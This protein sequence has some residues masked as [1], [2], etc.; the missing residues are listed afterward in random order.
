MQ[1][2][3]DFPHLTGTQVALVR[4]EASTGIVLL[5]SG[6][7]RLGAGAHYTTFESV[8]EAERYAATFLREHPSAECCFFVSP[9]NFFR[10]ITVN[11]DETRNA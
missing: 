6:A 4:A 9:D 3:D 7:Y 8:T 2:S 5:P 10:R 11:S 1:H